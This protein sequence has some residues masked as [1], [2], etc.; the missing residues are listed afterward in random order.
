MIKFGAKFLNSQSEERIHTIFNQSVVKS[1]NFIKNW[2]EKNNNKYVDTV[3][4]IF[5]GH[6]DAPAGGCC[7][8]GGADTS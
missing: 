5:V 7:C 2:R 4:H 8:G 1:D 3:R 6:V